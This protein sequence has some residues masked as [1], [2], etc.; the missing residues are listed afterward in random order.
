[1]G[2]VFGSW[3]KSTPGAR[4]QARAGVRASL[5]ASAA[6]M[7]A[8]AADESLLDAVVAAAAAC[9][10]A[11]RAGNKILFAGN[12]GSAADAQHLAAEL[13]GRLGH[14]RPGL[15]A[16]ALTADS[17]VLTAL[18]N[19]YGFEAAFARQV[20]SLGRPGDVLV[21]ITTSGRSPN[22]LAALKAARERGLATVA[23]T[24]AGGAA[25]AGA[26]DHL[27]RLPSTATQTVQEAHIAVGH[28]LCALIEQGAAP[29]KP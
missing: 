2:F 22:V 25:L 16:L 9:A 28:A 15:A 23:M 27:V 13:V 5:E 7:T 10:K 29:G 26:C 1:M 21:A 17:A 3:S 19:D 4:E 12:G 18:A 11:L 6:L 8:A 20:A 14:E 24:G